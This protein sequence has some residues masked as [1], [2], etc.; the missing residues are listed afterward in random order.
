[1]NRSAGSLYLLTGLIVGLLFGLIYSWAIDPPQVTNTHPDSLVLQAKDQYRTLTALAF[2]STGD[3]VR[4]RARLALLG[5]QDPY[6]ALLN[7]LRRKAA[8]GESGEVTA[9][10]LLAVALNQNPSPTLAPGP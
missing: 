10:R 6:P 2:V 7:L 4:A 8:L 5:E 1:M 3:L 9:L